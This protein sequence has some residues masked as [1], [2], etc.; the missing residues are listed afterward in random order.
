MPVGRD[1]SRPY[2]FVKMLFEP[3]FDHAKRRPQ[4]V[5][6]IDDRGRCTYQQ[7]AA[8]AAQLSSYLGAQTR[9]PR[10]GILLPSSA[11]FVAAFYGAMLAGKAIVPIN[12]LLSDRELVHVIRDS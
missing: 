9:Q 1:K 3:L 5:A 11:E 6:I 4:Q 12:F 7:L 10:L 8:R 2:G